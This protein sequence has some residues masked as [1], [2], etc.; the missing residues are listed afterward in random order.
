VVVHEHVDSTELLN[1]RVDHALYVIGIANVAL[2]GERLAPRL[3]DLVADLLQVLDLSA[4][5]DHRG[6]GLGETAGDVLADAGPSTRDD[7][8]LLLD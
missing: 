4:G 2:D 5:Q 7:R 6:A 8:D 3:Q 1:G